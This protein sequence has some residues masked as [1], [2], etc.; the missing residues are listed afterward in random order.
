MRGRYANSL[1]IFFCLYL[2][3]IA[4][5]QPEIC[6][7]RNDENTTLE[8]NLHVF[9]VK[10]LFRLTPK[11]VLSISD[12]YLIEITF[13][14]AWY[15]Y[16]G[17]HTGICEGCLHTTILRHYF[18]QVLQQTFMFRLEPRSSHNEGAGC[19]P[20]LSITVTHTLTLL[21]TV[22]AFKL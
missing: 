18:F 17:H 1:D 22:S 12:N 21:Y 19:S 16:Q 14:S 5:Q 4:C 6:A 8:R 9:R 7:K 10:L 20:S 15:E 11:L 2:H 3:P 13:V